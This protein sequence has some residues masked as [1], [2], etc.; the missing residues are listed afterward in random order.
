MMIFKK[1]RLPTKIKIPADGVIHCH[2]KHWIDEKRIILRLNQM[3]IKRPEA[4]LKLLPCT[5]EKKVRRWLSW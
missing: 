1:K 3:W 4:Y 2:P 5:Q